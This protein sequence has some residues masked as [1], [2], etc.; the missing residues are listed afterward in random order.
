[1]D[2]Q[3]NKIVKFKSKITG[4]KEIKNEFIKT[5]YEDELGIIWVGTE[6]KGILKIDRNS[7]R[8]THISNK[9]DEKLSLNA[10]TVWTFF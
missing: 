2:I 8:F 1:M 3:K 5:I 7:F 10:K 6:W 4:L 9:P